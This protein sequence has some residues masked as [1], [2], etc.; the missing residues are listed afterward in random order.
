VCKTVP[1]FAGNAGNDPSGRVI[2]PHTGPGLSG[3]ND[4]VKKI[5]TWQEMDQNRS[6]KRWSFP[7]PYRARNPGLPPT[8]PGSTRS[9]VHR[10]GKYR[11]NRI[12]SKSGRLL[13]AENMLF[14]AI[15]AASFFYGVL[16]TI[17]W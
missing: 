9:S 16:S 15:P 3:G 10:P 7:G 6:K 11:Y 14:I 4:A 5:G 1:V 13:W 12:F 17:A 8:F 2:R